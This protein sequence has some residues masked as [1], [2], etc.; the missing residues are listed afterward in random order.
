MIVRRLGEAE[1]T[2][3]RVVARNWE[4]TRLLLKADGLGFSM[5]VTTIHA[6]TVTPM[7]YR[8]HLGAV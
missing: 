5:H 1:Q 4:S 2:E 6:G 8:H 7:W 3:R